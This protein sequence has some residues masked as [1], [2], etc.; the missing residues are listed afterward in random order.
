[1]VEG[2]PPEVSEEEA[3]EF[4][5]TVISPLSTETFDKNPI[6]GAERHKTMGYVVLDFRRKE[7]ADLCLKLDGMNY[8]KDNSLKVQRVK[9]FL[10]RWNEEV[11]EIQKQA[12]EGKK[13]AAP[14]AESNFKAPAK[15]VKGAVEEEVDNKLYIGGLPTTMGDAEVRQLVESFGKLKSFNLVKDPANP[16]HNKGYAFFEYAD[17]RATE[18]ALKALNNYEVKDKRLKV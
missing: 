8:G 10:Q 9:R 13:P 3:K 15:K 16:D 17:D 5:Y 14:E 7:E 18:K 1:V 6:L 11:E 4:F 12:E 2:L